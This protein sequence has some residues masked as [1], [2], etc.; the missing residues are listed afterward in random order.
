MAQALATM[1]ESQ[2]LACKSTL[3]RVSRVTNPSASSAWDTKAKAGD[4]VIFDLTGTFLSEQQSL[5]RDELQLVQVPPQRHTKPNGFTPAKIGRPYGDL[6][7]ELDHPCSSR[8][9]GS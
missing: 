4:C 7:C 3:H 6:V 1:F 8:S 2:Y 5:L 9:L